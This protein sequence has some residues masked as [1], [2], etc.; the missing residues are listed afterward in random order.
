MWSK[1]CIVYSDQIDSVKY[2]ILVLQE[3]NLIYFDF[4][5]NV[6]MCCHVTCSSNI[7]PKHCVCVFGG[8]GERGG[9]GGFPIIRKFTFFVICFLFGR[10]ITISVLST[11]SEIL[12][13]Q[14]QCIVSFKSC[15]TY[16]FICFRELL[17]FIDDVRHHKIEL[18][19]TPWVL[20]KAVD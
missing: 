3:D 17:Y 10:K 9:G 13:A 19:G 11:F 14:N 6:F 20:I 12:F 18:C 4:L 2:Y 7:N 15:F 1:K 16:V 8:R 5:Q